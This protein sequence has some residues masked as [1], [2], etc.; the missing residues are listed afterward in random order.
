MN[1]Y[2]NI[3]LK[4]KLASSLSLGRCLWSNSCP[5]IHLI[6][7]LMTFIKQIKE[8]AGLLPA[9]IHWFKNSSETYLGL[10]FKAQASPSANLIWVKFAFSYTR[11]ILSCLHPFLLC[12]RDT[13][14]VPGEF[15]FGPSLQN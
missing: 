13:A 6:F 11:N 9:Y 3:K 8:L 10:N 1:I 5:V 7:F 12:A 15:Q 4:K 2:G 14:Q